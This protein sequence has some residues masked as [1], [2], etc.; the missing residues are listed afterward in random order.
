MINTHKT[1]SK[2]TIIFN[3]LKTMANPHII[4]QVTRTKNQT[5]KMEI[6]IKIINTT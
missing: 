1:K 3:T 5:I 2:M 6:I 4:N